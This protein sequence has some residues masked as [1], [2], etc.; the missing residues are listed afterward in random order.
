MTN[1]LEEH[2]GYLTDQVKL[3]RYQAAINRT[4]RPA[5]RVLDLGCGSGVLG[6][7]ALRAGA[8]KVIFV[9]EGAV[10]EV[11]RRTVADAGF[12]DKA[13]FFQINSF[14]LALSERVDIV[15]C[16]HVG[17]FGFDYGLLELLSDAK[18]RFLK[19]GGILIPTQLELKLA[20]IESTA[21]RKLV[22][23]WQDGSIP[24]DYSWLGLAAA[25]SK[26][27]M[28]LAAEDLIGEPA[29][30][31]TLEPGADPASFMSWDVEFKCARDGML[32]GIAGWFD[33]QLF[34]NIR[35]TNSPATPDNL[36]RPQAV[37]PLAAPVHVTAGECIRV[38][39]MV[40]PLDHLIGWVVELPEQDLK[41]S[42]N[43]FN[44]L[45]IDRNSLLRTQPDRIA[46]LNNRGQARQVVLSYCD[47]HRTVAEVQALIQQ[48]HPKLFPS[49]QAM[50]SFIA[51]ILAWDTGE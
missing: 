34:D 9:E 12:S 27:G 42:H 32:D 36:Q 7:M 37:F 40:R 14:Q 22:G 3:E 49:A 47:G 50:S 17:Y 25:N 48:E 28:Q 43:T 18:Q 45:L 16:D 33:C 15:V 6:L 38:N 31:A 35:M 20:P 11:A 23:Q 39:T 1:I 41:F 2:A 30:L 8:D 24:K 51:Q 19:P 13:E 4:V 46:A 29:S 21:C 26:H 44:G 10:I 5:H